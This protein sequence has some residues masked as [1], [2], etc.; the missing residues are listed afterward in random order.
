MS[1]TIGKDLVTG[2]TILQFGSTKRQVQLMP[3]E[4]TDLNQ[5][6]RMVRAEGKLI[7]EDLGKKALIFLQELGKAICDGDPNTIGEMWVGNGSKLVE[8]AIEA[9]MLYQECIPNPFALFYLGDQPCSDSYNEQ[10]VK[11]AIACTTEIKAI[12]DTL[13]QKISDA[14]DT[15][16]I[17]K[18]VEGF[19]KLILAYEDR[20]LGVGDT[21]TDE[22]I[23][24]YLTD[25]LKTIFDEKDVERIGNCFYD[26]IHS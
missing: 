17:D 4:G 26:V 16:A 9:E 18:E 15:F 20:G 10:M 19:G 6:L 13:F 24:K 25:K 8:K 11:E 23:W 22:Q 12:L 1:V 5:K 14:E 7:K 2:M 3:E 21:Q